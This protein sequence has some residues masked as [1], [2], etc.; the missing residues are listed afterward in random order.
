MVK[1]NITVEGAKEA[2]RELMGFAMNI[3]GTVGKVLQNG[4]QIAQKEAKRV[5]P[6][7]TWFM[8][9]NIESYIISPLDVAIHSRAPYS[10]WVNDGTRYQDAQPFFDYG[11]Q[12]GLQYLDDVMIDVVWGNIK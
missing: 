11:I 6:V 1:V 9:D 4:G 3:T 12:K 10:G 7:D 8:H 5:A 2:E